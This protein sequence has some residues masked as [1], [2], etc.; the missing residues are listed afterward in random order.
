MALSWPQRTEAHYWQQ[1][2]LTDHLSQHIILM[3]VLL[4]QDDCRTKCWWVGSCSP[5][6][7]TYLATRTPSMSWRCLLEVSKTASRS[8]YIF[9]KIIVIINIIKF[10]ITT[11][12]FH[13]HNLN[14]HI[15]R[16]RL[17]PPLSEVCR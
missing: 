3:I 16:M 5:T 11:I 17:A 13:L 6:S 10:I 7:R 15:C 12:L 2:S 4:N 1:Q 8:K 14:N 9:D